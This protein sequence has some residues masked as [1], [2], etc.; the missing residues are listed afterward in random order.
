ME[1]YKLNLLPHLHYTQFDSILKSLLEFIFFF[2]SIIFVFPSFWFM[3]NVLLT[4]SENST[5][6][7]T[8]HLPLQ[9]TLTG[10]AIRMLPLSCYS[11]HSFLR[12]K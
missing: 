6:G 10:S 8:N 2:Y 5:C 9:P 11:L 12:V 4:R 7:H 3:S 1:N